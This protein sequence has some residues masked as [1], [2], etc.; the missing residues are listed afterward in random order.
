MKTIFYLILFTLPIAFVQ[1]KKTK[2]I[3]EPVIVDIAPESSRESAEPKKIKEIIV[4]E[5]FSGTPTTDPFTLVSQRTSGDSLILEVQYGGGCKEHDFDM[6]TN[7]LWMKS[8]P[9]QLNLFLEHENH[10]DHC[11]AL[12]TETIVFDLKNC[13]YPGGNTVM[14]IINGDR[15]HMLR[16]TY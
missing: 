16:Y 11:R 9:P 5:D 14:V 13:R 6:F 12:L 15:E 7:R 1:C 8:M 4:K 3:P 10:D 2:G